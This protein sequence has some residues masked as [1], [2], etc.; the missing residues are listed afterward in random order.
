MKKLPVSLSSFEKG[1]KTLWDWTAALKLGVEIFNWAVIWFSVVLIMSWNE[2]ENIGSKSKN[3]KI[4]YFL[5]L[6]K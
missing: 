4:P 2:N 1:R 5:N 6:T 3:D